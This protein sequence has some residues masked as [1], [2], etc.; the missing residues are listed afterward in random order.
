MKPVFK[1]MAMLLALAL[2]PAFI[3][4]GLAWKDPDDSISLQAVS[5]W[6]ERAVLWV[7]ARSASDF[8]QGHPP[9]AMRL[10]EDEWNELLPE[11][12]KQWEPRRV[13]VVYCNPQQCHASEEVAKRLRNEVGLK[14]VYFLR[15]GYFHRRF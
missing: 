13:V 14:P 1:E 9:E 5:Q 10:N 6:P 8:A 7:D 3:S 4:F 15:G 11:L 12:L 2:L